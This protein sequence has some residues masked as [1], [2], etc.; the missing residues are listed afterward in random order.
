VTTRPDRAADDQSS[1]GEA[2]ATLDEPRGRRRFDWASASLL[3]TAA[4][5]LVAWTWG[6]WTDPVV[7]SGRELY[8]A[9]RLAMGD[10]LYR[11]VAYFNGPLSPYWNALWF[12]VLG[13]S[14]GVLTAVDALVGAGIVGL[15][16]AI[17]RIMRGRRVATLASLALL[18]L[19][20]I[21]PQA[22][23]GA[24]TFLAP[25]SHE[26]THGLL[27]LLL[28]VYALCRSADAP[29]RGWLVV[30][31]LAAGGSLLTK[32][33]M[34]LGAAAV[35]GAW[36]VLRGSSRRSLAAELPIVVLA[37]AVPPIAAVLALLPSLGAEGALRGVMAPLVSASNGEIRQ[38]SFY[39]L[40]MGTLDLGLSLRRIALGALSY[41]AVLGLPFLALRKLADRRTATAQPL[42][43]A[44]AVTLAAVPGIL[45]PL[46][47]VR[48]ISWWRVFAPLQLFLLFVLV[49]ELTGRFRILS[50]ERGSSAHL[51]AKLLAV[52]A[53]VLLTKIFLNVDV[54]FYG[55]VLAAPGVAILVAVTQGSLPDMLARRRYVAG[56]V[57]SIYAAALL[58]GVLLLHLVP[59]AGVNERRSYLVGSGGDRFR[60]DPVR[61]AVLQGVWDEVETLPP[62]QRMAAVPEGAMVN[63]LARRESPVP[64]PA[65]LPPEQ[66]LFGTAA[67]D[68]AFAQAPPEWITT[69]DRQDISYGA[70]GR[71]YAVDLARW[72][73]NRY[74]TV[75]S[76]SYAL[77]YP[78][79]LEP[80]TVTVR[81]LRL[82]DQ[83]TGTLGR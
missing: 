56:H 54:V 20:A 55:F 41:L 2:A 27:L 29:G 32:P 6:A 5:A 83:P 53:T 3:G 77:P 4:P 37:A 19:C 42:A 16:Y 10:T 62:D 79:S 52:L 45:I 22:D 71:E 69:W 33:E 11:D 57:Y 78:T 38:L 58:A 76:E 17:V 67:I 31:G 26:M 39:R 25:Y 21:P 50:A 72:I 81:L 9:W 60:T 70:F 47:S 64:F 7:D 82:T 1:A 14:I 48:W 12:R 51:A 15:T 75:R 46:L 61:G 44:L 35:L 18:V 28:L 66:A 65:I 34:A 73:L 24:Y 36:I 68:S 8:V 74:D 40:T 30:A 80:D 49:G 23:E 13:P 59:A 63:Y 43:V